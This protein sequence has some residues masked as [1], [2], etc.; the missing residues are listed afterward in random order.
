MDGL[1]GQRL[2][3]RHRLRPAGPPARRWPRASG[4][5]AEIDAARGPD[6]STGRSELAAADV[7]PGGTLDN[8]EYVADVVIWPDEVTRRRA[9]AALRRADLGRPAD[10]A[11]RRRGG[12][13]CWPAA[14]SGAASTEAAVIGRFTADRADGRIHACAA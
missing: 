13:A 10:R 12:R 1:P 4:V 2:H 7:V 11:S 5:D 14:S 8:L 6:R 3:R 9:A